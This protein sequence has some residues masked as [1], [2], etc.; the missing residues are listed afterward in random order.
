[1]GTVVRSVGNTIEI[2]ESGT[3]NVIGERNTFWGKGKNYSELAPTND[4]ERSK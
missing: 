3:S 1:M 4:G 2:S